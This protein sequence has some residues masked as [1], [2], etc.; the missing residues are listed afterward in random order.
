MIVER[1][2]QLQGLEETCQKLRQE[3]ATQEEDRQW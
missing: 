2:L 1:D 3:L